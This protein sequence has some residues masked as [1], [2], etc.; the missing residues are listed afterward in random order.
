MLIIIWKLYILY[1]WILFDVKLL[2]ILSLSINSDPM[3]KLTQDIL[4][5]YQEKF[6][7]YRL[8]RNEV[9]KILESLLKIDDSKYQLSHRI[10]SLD[11]LKHKIER[12]RLQG[13]IYKKLGDVK[14]VLGIRVVF[15]SEMDRKKFI[16]QLSKELKK[17]VEFIEKH[18]VSGYRSTH[19]IISFGDERTLLSEYGKFTGLKCEVQLTLI[20]NHAWAEVEH[21]ILYKDIASI[22]KLDE[23]EYIRLKNRM[24]KVMVE[25]IK[26]ASN[27]LESI[28]K[29]IRKL[30]SRREDIDKATN[31]K[32]IRS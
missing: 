1:I 14:D 12:K 19:A 28:V 32:K 20:M 31:V 30:R 2:R 18:K 9:C 22:H 11:S 5:E 10:K 16:K 7:L 21:D 26:K 3:V 13:K 17:Q 29:K 27:E 4:K 15:Y 6:N 25:Y 8:Y 23:K 24:E